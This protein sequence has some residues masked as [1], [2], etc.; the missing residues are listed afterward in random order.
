MNIGQ[1][2]R[3]FR[4]LIELFAA[5]TGI[6]MVLNTSFNLRGMPIVEHPDDALDCLYGARLDRLF[7]GDLEIAAPDLTAAV[8]VRVP[9]PGRG[10]AG[11]HAAAS[12]PP[13]VR[14]FLRRTMSLA[15]HDPHPFCRGLVLYPTNFF[16]SAAS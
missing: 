11:A 14:P 10:M 1:E 8:P 15:P 5:A 9:V 13:P 7:I 3:A 4:A 2:S 6:P 16:T 12:L